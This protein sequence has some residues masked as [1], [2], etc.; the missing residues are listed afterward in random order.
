MHFC[1]AKIPKELWHLSL[2]NLLD[3]KSSHQRLEDNNNKIKQ[4]ITLSLTTIS[5]LRCIEHQN[6]P[7]KTV[8]I[9]LKHL[10]IH[11]VN[12]NPKE[13]LKSAVLGLNNKIN[14]LIFILIKSQLNSD[15]PQMVS[16]HL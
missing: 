9:L 10:K 12:A 6:R 14:S 1:T 11:C 4:L 15:P 7:K 2:D 13:L 3:M 5:P 16:H 8:K